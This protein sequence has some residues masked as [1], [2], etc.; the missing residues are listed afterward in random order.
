MTGAAIQ[1][2]CDVDVM[3]ARCR[4]AIM[5]G[6]TVINDA[7]MIEASADKASGCMTDATI[8]V[9]WY[10]AGSFT[11]SVLAIM[12]GATVVYDASMIK[13]CWSKAC[14]LVAVN[15]IAGG[16]HMVRWRGFSWG[17]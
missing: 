11:Y 6:R 7:G 16:W 10:M 17:G 12:T 4:R 5:A 1:S 13:G 3:F 14:G 2:G 15:T 8:L 9:C